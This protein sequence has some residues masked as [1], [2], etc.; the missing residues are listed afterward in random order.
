MNSSQNILL[1]A[2]DLLLREYCNRL[3]ETPCIEQWCQAIKSSEVLMNRLLHSDHKTFRPD[4]ST[5]SYDKNDESHTTAYKCI[6]E[7]FDELASH[8]RQKIENDKLDETKLC[9]ENVT[10]DLIC[11]LIILCSV[12]TS[13]ASSDVQTDPSKESVP[14]DSWLSDDQAHVFYFI[15]SLY[16]RQKA[17]EFAT[18]FGVELPK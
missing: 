14:T 11:L 7:F 17:R 3:M 10:T 4:L 15:L 18:L 8:I 16:C 9:F 2:T 1:P 5:V 13:C 6:E 12:R